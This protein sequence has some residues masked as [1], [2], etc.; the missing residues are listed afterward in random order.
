MR[1]TLP[2]ADQ[3]SIHSFL[4]SSPVPTFTAVIKEREKNGISGTITVFLGAKY[5]NGYIKCTFKK[6]DT[7]DTNPYEG[8]I[9][10][11]AFIKIISIKE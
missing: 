11:A 2:L 9:A 1:W 7:A 6:I 3:H 10:A 5:I 4:T 8:L